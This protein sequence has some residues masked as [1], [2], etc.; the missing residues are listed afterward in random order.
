MT[1]SQTQFQILGATGSYS[2]VIN[3][4]FESTLQ[5]CGGK[6]VYHK[7]ENGDIWMEYDSNACE[8]NVLNTAHRG[9][10]WG[11]AS[12]K[13]QQDVNACEGKATW[14]IFDGK[15]WADQPSV[16]LKMI[17][18][19]DLRF[20]APELPKMPPPPPPTASSAFANSH[21][22][23][24]YGVAPT[25]PTGVSLRDT[26]GAGVP[27]AASDER[28]SVQRHT[29]QHTDDSIVRRIAF[30]DSRRVD[31]EFAQHSWLSER[32]IFAS[33]DAEHEP[34]SI[35]MAAGSASDHVYGV[36]SMSPA[37]LM[38]GGLSGS[39]SSSSSSSSS[40]TQ[41]KRPLHVDALEPGHPK[42]IIRV[43]KQQMLPVQSLLEQMSDLNVRIVETTAAIIDSLSSE[44]A[45][46]KMCIWS[47]PR[48]SQ[49]SE[50]YIDV[51]LASGQ[52]ME[53]EDD[54]CLVRE[55]EE[56]ASVVFYVASG[57]VKFVR[58]VRAS[59]LACLRVRVRDAYHLLDLVCILI[60]SAANRIIFSRHGLTNA[61]P[62]P[63]V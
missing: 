58:C 13:T 55:G 63:T 56:T 5:Q 23:R 16:R 53:T 41:K 21:S 49:V 35:E 33:R 3:G 6:P 32:Q 14:K 36:P 42:V 12:F 26:R 60:T 17:S 57:Q 29:H 47:T 50:T 15:R 48:F 25:H 2:D 40:L 43:S 44:R 38:L 30:A 18:Y 11:Y 28:G 10:S 39:S 24:K 34:S 62:L 8:W 19:G 31:D 59:L 46:A 9:L 4:V 54:L 52:R 61:P 22:P 45:S 1:N 20:V 37:M 7:R 51:L 27:L